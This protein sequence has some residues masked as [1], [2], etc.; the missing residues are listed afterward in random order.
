MDF[1]YDA[2][3]KYR[4]LCF[5]VFRENIS[6]NP[7]SATKRRLPNLTQNKNANFLCTCINYLCQR[8][9]PEYTQK[10]F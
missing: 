9:Q 8:E 1:C 10:K 7:R 4:T 2:T 5:K 3:R 6:K